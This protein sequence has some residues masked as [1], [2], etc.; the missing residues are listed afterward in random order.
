[1]RHSLFIVRTVGGQAV[2]ILVKSLPKRGDISVTKYRE[3]SAEERNALIATGAFK[4]H[5]QSS[6]VADQGLR[7]GKPDGSALRRA[8]RFRNGCCVIHNSF[9]ST[10][11]V[12]VT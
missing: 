1:M 8:G 4:S 5:T 11:I 9:S 3:Y 6:Q 7:G 12:L 10:R 2:A